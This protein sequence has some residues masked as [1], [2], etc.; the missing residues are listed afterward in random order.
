[1][2]AIMERKETVDTAVIV[3]H[4]EEADG[5]PHCRFEREADAYEVDRLLDGNMMIWDIR[6]DTDAMGFCHEHYSKLLASR[7][8]FSVAVMLESHLRE[9]LNVNLGEPPYKNKKGK[10]SAAGVSA[11]SCDCYICRRMTRNMFN[12]TWGVAE[13]YKKRE[14]FRQLFAQKGKLCFSHYAQ[15]LQV[16]EQELDSKSYKALSEEIQGD[17]KERLTKLADEAKFYCGRFDYRVTGADKEFGETA[18]VLERVSKFLY[19]EK[20]PKL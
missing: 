12:F 1:M 20:E 7:S 9:L 18:D 10:A 17:I 8:R 19:K 4:Y 13:L 6:R 5:C 11:V 3:R 2:C 16:A 15:L 14:D